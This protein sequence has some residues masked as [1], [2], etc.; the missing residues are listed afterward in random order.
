MSTKYNLKDLKKKPK[1]NLLNGSKN[2]SN[3]EQETKQAPMKRGRKPKEAE[4]RLTEKVTVNFTVDEIK[5]L[6]EL[7]AQNF[8]VP[9]PTLI[10]GFLKEQKII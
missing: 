4:E 5:A 10:R 3:Q 2:Q 7:S 1:R 6:K 9:L 8:N